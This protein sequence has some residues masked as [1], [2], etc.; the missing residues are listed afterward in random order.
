M[1]KQ[2]A[3]HS[4]SLYQVAAHSF[5]PWML[6][7]HKPHSHSQTLQ[8]HLRTSAAHPHTPHNLHNLHSPLRP[9][10]QH[11]HNAHSCAASLPQSCDQP[12]SSVG[13]RRSILVL[14]IRRRELW[15]RLC[16][17]PLRCFGWG[18]CRVLVDVGGGLRQ[19]R[20]F[21][22]AWCLLLRAGRGDAW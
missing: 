12:I 19:R 18:R 10:V 2:A 17:W 3:I 5:P 22:E 9:A 11:P 1:Q 8:P 16:Q 14:Q 21:R 6:K 4:S 13:K 20:P 7:V 15:V